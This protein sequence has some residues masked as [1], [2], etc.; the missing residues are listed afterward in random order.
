MSVAV[1][2]LASLLAPL[3]V[4]AF[5][6]DF[7]P[8]R[9]CVQHGALSR[10]P[11]ILGA[12]ELA[13]FE[14][15]ARVYGGRV[16]FA[17]GA[18]SPHMV[19]IETVNAAT[20][21]NMGLMVY[22]DDV[23]S[24]IEGMGAFLQELEFDFGVSPGSVR[25]GAFAAPQSGGAPCHYDIEDV[26]SIQL[27]GDKTFEIAPVSEIP[28]PAGIQYTPGTTPF[29]DLYPQAGEGFPEWQDAAF[30]KVDM[31]P[32]S[33]LFMPRGTWHRTRAGA[34]S[35]SVSILVRPPV[36]VDAILDQLRLTL[37]R[38]PQ[39][40]QPLY[41]LWS[42][43]KQRDTALAQIETLL[44]DLPVKAGSLELSRLQLSLC[45]ESARVELMDAD[46]R[47]QRAPNARVTV[48]D[49]RADEDARLKVIEVR[50]QEDE[51]GERTG[52]RMGILPAAVPLFEWLG[53][54][55]APFT[56]GELATQFTVPGAADI[57]AILEVCV[58]AGLLKILYF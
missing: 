49:P 16:L 45:P 3:S 34:N 27:V 11:D 39:W 8:R 10:L 58:K 14:A 15:L 53:E 56:A 5:L 29:D 13:S 40:R 26:I 57:K 1:S 32:G 4:D 33:V 25:I 51:F 7:W 24:C 19:P 18:N 2:A 50:V 35:L 12:P 48:T 9:S 28:C 6:T 20:L 36:A 38:D 22:L 42:R 23:A 41:G 52:V 21:F 30:E 54:S 17:N 44:A 46:T 37:L 55:R 43:G 31:T 47:L